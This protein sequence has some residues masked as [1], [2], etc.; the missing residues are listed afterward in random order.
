[1][2]YGDIFCESPNII[3]DLIIT[4]PQIETYI[5]DL[6]NC[7]NKLEFNNIQTLSYYKQIITNIK[8]INKTL[9][10]IT[11]HKPEN[12][13][14]N[15]IFK[16]CG[17]TLEEPYIHL[18]TYDYIKNK[19][20]INFNVINYLKEIHYYIYKLPINLPPHKKYKN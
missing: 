11:F 16:F 18:L 1:M 4:N 8:K 19:I 5:Y 20:C 14:K 13:H 12:Y 9:N 2:Y 15:D 3:T 7:I 17:F 10:K 6:K